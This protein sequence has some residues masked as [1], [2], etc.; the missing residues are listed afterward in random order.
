MH[1]IIIPIFLLCFTSVFTLTAYSEED[2]FYKIQKKRLQNPS[3]IVKK[4]EALRQSIFIY[5]GLKEEDVD[6]AMDSQFSR[7]ENMMFI[8]TRITT[9]A[10]EEEVQEEGCD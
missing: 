3:K 2:R 8:R 4:A 9:E 6:S 10:G 5:D 1:K 7:I